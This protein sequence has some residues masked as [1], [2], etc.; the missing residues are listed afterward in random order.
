MGFWIADI[1]YIPHNIS[2]MT[3]PIWKQASGTKLRIA[4]LILVAFVGAAATRGAAFTTNATADAFVTTRPTGNLASG[5]FGGAG[6]VGLSAPGWPQGE[7]QSVLKFGLSDALS[8][9]NTQFGAGQWSVQSVTLQLTA[10]TANNPIFNS[11]APGSFA[12][13]W[14]Q[15]DSWTEGTGGPGAPGATGVTFSSLQA[16]FTSPADT[17]LGTFAFNGAAS[18]VNAYSLGLAPGLISDIRSGTDMSLRLFASDN[19]VSALFNSRNFGTAANRPLLT[20]VAVPE[21]SALAMGSFGMVLIAGWRSVART[22][23]C[24][25]SPQ[26]RTDPSAAAP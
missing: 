8:A 9:F 16:M 11:N 25:R 1:R 20:I 13:A 23:K 14:M 6:S 17:R 22:R 12:I 21:S 2:G 18:G 19:A 3:I 24:G 4:A 26:R 15:N 5:N 7:F 10:T